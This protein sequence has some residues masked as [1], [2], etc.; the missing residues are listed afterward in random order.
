V[1]V[2]AADV[3][4]MKHWSRERVKNP[5]VLGVFVYVVADERPNAL[6][7]VS[8][9]IERHVSRDEQLRCGGD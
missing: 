5:L 4:L 6:R 9:P 3:R 1:D 8:T 7:D 2:I